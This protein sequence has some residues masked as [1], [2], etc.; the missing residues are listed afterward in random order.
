MDVMIRRRAS[1]DE[2]EKSPAFAPA[3]LI[4]PDG[5]VDERE[6]SPPRFAPALVDCAALVYPT[7]MPDQRRSQLPLQHEQLPSLRRKGPSSG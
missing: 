2:A 3:S 4:K 7:G 1:N 6:R 5:R